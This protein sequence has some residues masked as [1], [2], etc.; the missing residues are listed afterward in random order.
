M[1]PEDQADYERFKKLLDR[2]GKAIIMSAE[3]ETSEIIRRRLFEWGGLPDDAKK[4]AAAYA[5]WVQDHRP[6]VPNWFPVDHATEAFTATYPF[7]PTL[8]SVFERKWQSLPRFQRTRGILRLLALWVSYAYQ[9]GLSRAL[10]RTPSSPWAP[11]RSTTRCSAPPS[12][13]SSASRSSRAPSRPTSAARRTP[14]PCG[15]TTRRPRRSRRHGSTRRWRRRSSSSRTAAGSKAEATLPEIR[16]AVAEPDLDIGN[17]ETV[18]EALSTTCYYLSAE[19]T[20]TGS[21]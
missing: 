21:A 10:T 9:R 11:P 15:S 17:V 2:L 19:R 13:S 6:Q 7:H 4:T 14:T 5:D 18:L 3:T 8:L 1:T 12:S 16:L 20:A